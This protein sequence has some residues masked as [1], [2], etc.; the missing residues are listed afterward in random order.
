[1]EKETISR[2]TKEVLKI[3]GFEGDV[4][5]I[6]EPEKNRTRIKIES[7][8]NTGLLIGKNGEN[9]R[10]LQHLILLLVARETGQ[11]LR[12]GEFILDI[13]NYQQDRENYLIALAKNT[14]QEVLDTKQP[15]E[16][17]PMVASERRTI[18]I[19]LDGYEGVR[20][21]SVGER[22]ERRVVVKLI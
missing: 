3:M 6:E 18:H 17:E 11:N 21:E 16:L 8:E 20:T 9:L 1:M 22:G 19:T 5:L 7:P 10:A 14:A 12:P 15:K 13:N 2:I 4:A